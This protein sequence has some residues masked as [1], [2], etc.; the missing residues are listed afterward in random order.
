MSAAQFN[1]RVIEITSGFKPFAIN[2]TKDP[3]SAKDLIQETVFKALSNRDKFREG[4]NLSAWLF[5]IMRNIFIN[6]Y[7]KKSKRKTI[8][9]GT[10]NSYYINSVQHIVKNDAERKFMMDDI[11]NAISELSDDFRIPFMM[12]YEGFKYLEIA[13]ELELP[14]G[15]VK[16]RIFFAR[17]QLKATLILYKANK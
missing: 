2:L 5:T 10:D 14:L 16:S 1:D 11:Q 4:T 13:E 12:H 8:T 3:E 6:A 9:D 7:R 15:T 17:K